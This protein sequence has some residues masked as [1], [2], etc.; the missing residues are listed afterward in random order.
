MNKNLR[1]LSVNDLMMVLNVRNF[2]LSWI[3]WI[4]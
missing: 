2:C 1:D 4:I 3:R